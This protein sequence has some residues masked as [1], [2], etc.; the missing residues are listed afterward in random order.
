MTGRR[1][2]A[3]GAGS[4][5]A[6]AAAA[7]KGPGSSR[8]VGGPGG[9]ACTCGRGRDWRSAQPPQAAAAGRRSRPRCRACCVRGPATVPDPAHAPATPLPA[10]ISQ[11]AFPA[12]LSLDDDTRFLH[13]VPGVT[14]LELMEHVKQLYPAAGPFVLKFL[15]K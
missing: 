7:P 1:A 3:N 2:A 6:V 8:A 11:I 15:D 5:K 12:K 14:Y 9:Q 10:P 13:L 4:K